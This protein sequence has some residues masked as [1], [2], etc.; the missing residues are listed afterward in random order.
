MFT[1]VDQIV[2]GGANLA[3]EVQRIVIEKLSEELKKLAI[4]CLLL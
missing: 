4:S 2:K 1:S 3:I